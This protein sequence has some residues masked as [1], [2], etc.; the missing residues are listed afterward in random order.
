MT[1]P[2]ST[3]AHR[4]DIGYVL[5]I[6]A[7]AALGGILFGYDTAVIS[8]AVD[9][10]RAY[11]SL[12][13]AETGWAVSNVVIGCVVGALSA[14]WVAGCLGRKKALVL[15]AVLFTVSAVGAAVVD[16][17]V[18]FV[19]YRMIGGLAVGLAATVSPMYMSEVS[20]KNMRGRALGMQSIAIVAGQVIVFTV[21][22]LIARDVAA[23]WLVDYGW[24][25]MIGSEV[26]PCILF[27]IMVF[28]IP[29]SPRWQVMV[30]QD[31]KALKTLTRIS[32]AEHAGHLLAEIKDSL[33]QDRQGRPQKVELRRSGLGVILFVGCMLAMLQQVSGV[34]VM[35]YYAPMVLKGVTASTESA[36]FQTIW[37]GVMQLVGTLIGAWLIDRVG[38]IPLMKYGTIGSVSG[39][40]ITSYAMYTHQD[41]YLTLFGMLLFMLLYALSWGIGTWVLISEIFP[42]R[43]RSLGMSVAVCSMWIANF[44]VTQTFPMINDHPYLMST[45]NGAFPMWLFAGFGVFSYWFVIRFVPETRGV[46]LEKMEGVMLTKIRRQPMPASTRKTGQALSSKPI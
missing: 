39:L 1:I 44:L 34:N 25:W 43:L 2:T 15:A 29:E 20:P 30:G 11:F 3:H 10:L 4:H 42:N 13:A 28:T 27:C 22:Y 16:S 45:F 31:D 7:V 6:C 36:L 33:K 24:R 12:S 17:F 35:M 14:G 5:R 18:W 41:G 9:S 38:R 32:N 21:N 19:I 37:I 46:S 26:V 8:G 40:L 23:E